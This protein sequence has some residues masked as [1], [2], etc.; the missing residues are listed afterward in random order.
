MGYLRTNKLVIN[1]ALSLAAGWAWGVSLIVGMQTM[2][3]KGLL[4][5]VIW[6]TANS[7]ALPV[8]GYVS[9]RI[10]KLHSVIDSK[11]VQMFNTLIMVFCLLIQMNAIYDILSGTQLFSEKICKGVPILIA[12]LMAVGLFRNGLMRNV[13]LDKPLWLTCYVLLL[14]LLLW[15]V[16]FHLPRYEVGAYYETKDIYWALN[17]CLILFAGPFMNIQNWQMAEKLHKEQCLEISHVLAGVFFAFYMF[18][19][20]LLSLFHFSKTMLVLQACAIV[21]ITATTMDASVVGMQKIA[22]NKI[23]LGIA[24]LTI[25]FW[26]SFVSMGALELWTIMGNW[27]KHVAAVCII[28]ALIWGKV[29]K[30]KKG[31][32]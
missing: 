23:G 3:T 1:Y 28:F 19:I 2:Q 12:L 18:L 17:S 8:F 29:D 26:Q 22:G 6:A 25:L 21:C 24:I 9:F 10:R 20:A 11:P 32:M 7:L 30:K 4:P 5:Y 31:S 14:L 13:F 16:I 27:R 15:G